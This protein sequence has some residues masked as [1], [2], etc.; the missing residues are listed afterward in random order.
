MIRRSKYA[1]SG[2]AAFALFV[3]FYVHGC[4]HEENASVTFPPLLGSVEFHSFWALEW[5]T[6]PSRTITIRLQQQSDLKQLID[7][8]IFGNFQPGMS[9]EEVLTRFGEPSQTRT[10]NFGGTWSRYTTALGYVEIGVDRRTSPTDDDDKS[11]VP[12]R[13]S[14]QA[15]KDKPLDAIFRAPM[16]DV[17]RKA[18]TM[19]PVADER[20]VSIFDSK[21]GLILDMWMKDDRIERIELFKPADR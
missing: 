2:L 17:M 7:L 4:E 19:T 11:S 6:R 13:R 1:I 12:G 15:F 5:V 9:D 21:H 14:L 3:L 10:D 16:V 18:V 8:R 20:E